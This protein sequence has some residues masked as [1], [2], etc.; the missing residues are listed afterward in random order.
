MNKAIANLLNSV[1][2]DWVEDLNS[3]Q[4]NLSIFSGKILL[5][6]LKLKPDFLDILA[7]PFF[8]Q[9]G[10]VGQIEVKIP[11]KNWYTQPFKVKVKDVC[12]LLKPVQVK[13]WSAEKE[14]EAV[15]KRR[16]FALEHFE[17]MNPDDFDI[18][19]EVSENGIFGNKLLGNLQVVL[20]NVYFRYEDTFYSS[21]DFTFGGFIEKINLFNCD[22]L[23]EKS[24][25]NK[26][27]LYKLL[28]LN[29]A[30]FFVDYREGIVN[31]QEW[32][33][34]TVQD[35]LFQLMND[36]RRN[37]I[38][39]QYILHPMSIR[40]QITINKDSNLLI[41]PFS[42]SIFGDKLNVEAS[43]EQV[44]FLFNVKKFATE[45]LLFKK[46]VE[47]NIPERNFDLDE[48]R[49]YRTLYLEYRNFCKANE[50]FIEGKEEV[51]R[52]L[53]QCETGIFLNDIKIQRK[54]V[55]D[56]LKLQKLENEKKLEL[57]K[58]ANNTGNTLAK[59]LFKFV[60]KKSD[61]KADLEEENQQ[62]KLKRMKMDL[63]K[64]ELRDSSMVRQLTKSHAEKLD[65]FKDSTKNFIS[66][67]FG[68]MKIHL[69]DDFKE[70]LLASAT[71]IKFELILRL[72]SLKFNIKV[73]K[74]CIF[75]TIYKE[76]NLFQGGFEVEFDDLDKKS[77]RI[78][79]ENWET[80]F[81]YVYFSELVKIIQ[82]FIVENQKTDESLDSSSESS[83]KTEENE[84]FMMIIKD[85]LENGIIL[86]YFLQI[87]LKNFVFFL[88]IDPK[89][90]ELG[91]FLCKFHQLT[92]KTEQLL[93]GLMN[94]D[95]Y[96][97][98]IVDL[99]LLLNKNGAQKP[100][101]W[102]NSMN[103]QLNICKTKQFYRTGYK[104]RLMM[105]QIRLNFHETDLEAL[106][107]ALNNEKQ[108]KIQSELS[109]G[110]NIS[111]PKFNL[112]N[113]IGDLGEI[114]KVKFF[115]QVNSAVFQLGTNEN[116]FG[117]T[118]NGLECKSNLTKSKK[119]LYSSRIKSIKSFI[120]NPSEANPCKIKSLQ[121][122]FN[123][124]FVHLIYDYTLNIG[125]IYLNINPLLV[126]MLLK[127][128]QVS[129]R[130]GSNKDSVARNS[131]SN[132]QFVLNINNS[133]I[134]IN[135]LE[136][137]TWECIR[138]GFYSNI[139]YTVEV[140]ELVT[141]ELDA[142]LGHF[143][144]SLS[145]SNMLK[146]V[147][148]P[149]RVSFNFKSK[150]NLEMNEKNYSIHFESLNLT[151]GFRDFDFI[152][153]L[154]K[155]YSEIFTNLSQNKELKPSSDL[156][157]DIIVDSIQVQL[158]DDT[159]LTPYPLFI[160]K[161]NT[162]TILNKSN[163]FIISG[164][165]LCDSFDNQLKIWQPLMHS[166]KFI[167]K[168][169]ND[170]I[171]IVSEDDLDLNF[172]SKI[173]ENL[174]IGLRKS[175]QTV[176]DWGEIYKSLSENNE[177]LDYEIVNELGVDCVFWFNFHLTEK[178]S[179]KNGEKTQFKYSD[180]E[181]KHRSGL[182]RNTVSSLQ[183]HII[184]LSI[185][186]CSTIHEIQIQ[187]NT[188]QNFPFSG[189]YGKQ[190]LRKSV[191]ITE[192]F[193]SIKLTN[194]FCILNKTQKKLN[195]SYQ[196]KKFEIKKKFFV[197]VDWD[198]DELYLIGTQPELIEDKIF[199]QI[200]K[201]EFIGCYKDSF[202]YKGGL[203]ENGFIID[204]PYVFENFLPYDVVIYI[205]D[206]EEI[207]VCPGEKKNFFGIGIEN[208]SFGL[209]VLLK[210]SV[211]YTDNFNLL[212]SEQGVKI[213]NEF[214]WQIIVSVKNEKCTCMKV[215]LMCDFLVLN[216]SQ[217]DIRIKD[218]IIPKNSI[219]FMRAPKSEKIKL[220]LLDNENC[221]KSEKFNLNT[222][223]LSECI[224]LS[225]PESPAIFLALNL[226]QFSSYT[227]ILKIL[228]RYVI[229]N[230]LNI[231]LH[232]RQYNIKENPAFYTLYPGESL[233][234]SLLNKNSL[235]T[236][237]VSGN[238]TDWSTG[239]NINNLDDFQIKLK[240]TPLHPD[241]ENNT[242][243][244]N[245]PSSL[246]NFF[247]YLRVTVYSQNQA[248][249]NILFRNPVDP[250]F[251]IVNNTQFDLK[252]RQF[253][254]KSDYFV[255]PKGQSTVWVFEN[256]LK[257]TRRVQ[258]KI[259]KFKE[260]FCIEEVEEKNRSIG[261]F[262]VKRFGCGNTRFLEIFEDGSPDNQRVS[263]PSL[264]P[265]FH[266]TYLIEIKSIYVSLFTEVI[267]QKIGLLL[268]GLNCKYKTITELGENSTVLLSKM[269]FILSDLQIDNMDFL[270]EN[271]PVI[272]KRENYDPS[273]PF[274]QFRYK[275][276]FFLLLNQSPVDIFHLFEMQVQ[277]FYLK[278]NHEFL[279]ATFNLIQQ[280]LYSFYSMPINNSESPDLTVEYKIP[281]PPADY[282]K[283]YF[284]FI[285]IHACNLKFSFR[286]Q[287]S[288][289][290][291]QS[292]PELLR[293]LSNK[294]LDF[295]LITD[296]PLN[297]KEVIIE[298]SFQDRFSLLWEIIRNYSKQS[299]YQFYRVL[300]ATEILGNPI[301]LLDK[302]GTGVYEF[303]SEPAKGLLQGPKP[304]IEGLSKG[305]KSL[306]GNLIS[307]SLGSVAGIAGSLYNIISEEHSGKNQIFN[308]LGLYDLKNGIKGIVKPYKYYRH[309]GIKGLFSGVFK[310]IWGFSIAPVVAFL[311]L[312]HT[313]THR[314][315]LE[316]NDL[317]AKDPDFR[318]R[319]GKFVEVD[320]KI[321]RDLLN[322]NE[323][324]CY[325]IKEIRGQRVRIVV[326]IG[327]ETVIVTEKMLIVVV[328][329][330]VVKR[331]K[332]EKIV[333]IEVHSI[334]EQFV[335]FIIRVRDGFSIGCKELAPLT[336]VY[337]TLTGMIR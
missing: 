44:E 195:F 253:K 16:K 257:S 6:N 246:N 73:K 108:E 134:V 85:I 271:F 51:K 31:C 99:K 302:L 107:K 305:T 90:A 30:F 3:E 74:L 66:L 312:S 93:K 164:S 290:I 148:R 56:E 225:P 168:I 247:Y 321:S 260:D 89:N 86:S 244:W 251:K 81:D 123:L 242:L 61:S 291:L 299:L 113:F 211:L 297:L 298:N 18:N 35:S 153:N 174:G 63:A 69:F 162:L 68:S 263:L 167:T 83:L 210:D 216:N 202:E 102:P 256:Y 28:L 57:E 20:E 277:P 101:F 320:R 197:P 149:L 52:R 150:E 220:C 13:D 226:N 186:K 334:G 126:S 75:N 175:M 308:D 70:Y 116:C 112:L 264:G 309:D 208:C 9:S 224:T 180:I 230:D 100:I 330:E 206:R 274:F 332:L 255:L 318:A 201:E 147:N 120:R 262:S 84:G 11:W 301:G 261:P 8:L 287:Q 95:C 325:F 183:G 295:A 322:L 170:E 155:T 54:A 300:G 115:F 154:Q 137:C 185:P 212:K 209:Q 159:I 184:S 166:W 118:V 281:N 278:I 38:D 228:P 214:N 131:F 231:L 34:G 284:K 328:N 67:T 307:G 213:V 158:L 267:E 265:K 222:V 314:L 333:G 259:G 141:S 55:L 272:V 59:S 285:R 196:E 241:P 40:M 19:F 221:G 207:F 250:D 122:N 286:K 229:K 171:L 215:S 176:D 80:A 292:S 190:T 39:H 125:N 237:Q 53:S 132:S 335:L 156:S 78:C 233:H 252:L 182:F 217:Y 32:Y 128:S 236:I 48:I 276:E 280:M 127:Y 310:G 165:F 2:R 248:S 41:P 296:S 60:I 98:E 144:V 87:D 25:N 311:H 62:N 92:I 130:D 199:V 315:A 64:L 105:D 29:N 23:W 22:S 76:K 270:S 327:Y 111:S 157:Q 193:K 326:E 133:E 316:A 94:Y 223:G 219:G 178:F 173:L 304:F 288:S 254:T 317:S 21:E 50:N 151:L 160:L 142:Q 27:V 169:Q 240:L 1:L 331:V 273:T 306:F 161:V 47:D 234:F 313:I 200:G 138:L 96:K 71:D 91:H 46:N 179:L 42:I 7:L 336:K 58:I 110:S 249:I 136:R 121:L 198:L 235:A 245:F 279:L 139:I 189:A 26:E 24:N 192:K 37:L 79:G 152:R 243:D 187:S 191:K 77:A 104:I 146:S 12:I 329:L 5:K 82:K 36:E 135:S 293:V 205:E 203:I 129:K 15:S 97:G 114:M 88:P 14:Y 65:F 117:F 72:A 172:T 124:D 323:F 238:L 106:Q 269:N 140:K 45:H 289:Q 177:N 145:N 188:A 227:K 266:K 268:S 33:E 319:I 163:S 43:T 232:I 109:E 204:A 4:L 275:R 258:V 119:F 143:I 49:A 282:K 294:F 10:T 181:H 324:F 17:V 283:S 194:N 239:F 218:F 337:F 303:F 103:F